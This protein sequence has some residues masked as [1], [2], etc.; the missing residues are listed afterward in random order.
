VRT[1]LLDG[2][3]TGKAYLRASS[4]KLP[5]L[6]LDLRGQIDIVLAARV[7]AVN[8]RLRA[9]FEDLPDAPVGTVVLNLQGGKKGLLQNSGSLCHKRERATIRTTGHNGVRD[10]SKAVLQVSCNGHGRHKRH[11]RRLGRASRAA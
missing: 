10:S 5:D 3:L 4:H 1:P 7:D 11:A 2:P 8:G 9:T 6:V